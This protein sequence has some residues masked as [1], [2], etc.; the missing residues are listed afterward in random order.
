MKL[1]LL[2][3]KGVGNFYLIAKNPNDAEMK[4]KHLLNSSDY[5]FEP[6]RKVCNIQLIAEEE[7][8]LGNCPLVIAD[9]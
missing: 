8:S 1:Y 9:S 2:S 7:D 5:G 6:S 4:L 3:T